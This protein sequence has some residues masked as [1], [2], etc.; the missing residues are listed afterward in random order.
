MQALPGAQ[1]DKVARAETKIQKIDNLG[2]CFAQGQTPESIIE[3]GF[4]GLSPRFL[5]S[6]RVEFYCRCSQE[7]MAAHLKNLPKEDRTDILANG[8]FPLELRC[9]HCNS[10]Y[11]FSQEELTNVLN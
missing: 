3:T 8:P 2:H 4:A 5:D 1:P 7:R 11:R 10:V 9:H 6:S